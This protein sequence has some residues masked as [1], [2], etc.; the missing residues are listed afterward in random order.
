MRGLIRIRGP[1][2]A[3]EQLLLVDHAVDGNGSASDHRAASTR[4][5]AAAPHAAAARCGR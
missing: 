1:V 2:I 5:G 3:E 4:W